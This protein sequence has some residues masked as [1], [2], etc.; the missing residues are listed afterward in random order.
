MN[1]AMMAPTIQLV[2]VENSLRDSTTNTAY[3]TADLITTTMM[4]NDNSSHEDNLFC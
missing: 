1:L 3:A 4:T 2:P